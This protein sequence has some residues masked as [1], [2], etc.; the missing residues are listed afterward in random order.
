MPE[1]ALS[2]GSE[3]K[4]NSIEEKLSELED[5]QLLTK[6]DIISIKEHIEKL[7][8]ASA[9]PELD[10]KIRILQDL[11]GNEKLQD[12]DSVI[13][14]V[15]SLEARMESVNVRNP[16]PEGFE[17]LV[18]ARINEKLS[19][20]DKSLSVAG[21][22]DVSKLRDELRNEIENLSRKVDGI[23]AAASP[24]QKYADDQTGTITRESGARLEDV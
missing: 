11:A 4:L 6:L 16:A 19:G 22:P 24:A 8:P 23:R 1:L 3:A 14:K 13:K 20:M 2:T 18:D 21:K 17:K 12:I 10:E 15:E 9:A 7:S 5:M